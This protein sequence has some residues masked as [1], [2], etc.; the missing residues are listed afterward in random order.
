LDF[1]YYYKYSIVVGTVGTKTAM[2]FPP[3]S[4]VMDEKG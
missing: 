3:G 1:R 4:A 2:P